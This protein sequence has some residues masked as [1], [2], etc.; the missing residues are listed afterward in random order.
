MVQKAMG[1]ISMMKS[2]VKFSF[3]LLVLYLFG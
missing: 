1:E 3:R 2:L